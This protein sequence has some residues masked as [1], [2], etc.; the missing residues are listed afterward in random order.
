VNHKVLLKVLNILKMK[1]RRRPERILR[2]SS[3]L[4]DD[5]HRPAQGPGRATSDRPTVIQTRNCSLKLLNI[6]KIHFRQP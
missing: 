2:I 6:L 1:C 4:S 5:V 3:I